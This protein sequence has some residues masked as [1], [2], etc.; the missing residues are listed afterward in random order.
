[1]SYMRTSYPL[2]Y[3][4]GESKSYVFFDGYSIMDYGDK[5]DDDKSFIELIGRIVLRETNDKEYAE[6]IIKTLAKKM[7]IKMSG[8]IGYDPGEMWPHC[9]TCPKCHEVFY[10]SD[11][12]CDSVIKK[13]DIIITCAS[14]LHEFGYDEWLDGIYND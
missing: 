8:F 10:P 6:K 3:F 4:K 1:M 12:S 5:Y 2:K 7:N 13:E 9:V 11:N 14:C